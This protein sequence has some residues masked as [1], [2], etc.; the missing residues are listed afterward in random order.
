YSQLEKLE[1]FHQFIFQDMIFLWKR[2]L[3]F[4]LQASDLQYLIV[5][6]QSATEKLDFVLVEKMI[7]APTVEWEKR[8]PFTGN[9]FSFEPK[10]Y[11]DAVIVP[12][13]KPLG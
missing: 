2:Q 12:S 5:P 11:V 6:L 7:N 9:K 1:K 8:P 13:Y 4:D 3:D 10:E